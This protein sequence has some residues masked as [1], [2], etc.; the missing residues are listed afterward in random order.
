MNYTL[1]LLNG[2]LMI[3][4]FLIQIPFTG[5]M[6]NRIIKLIINHT[7]Q[8]MTPTCTGFIVKGQLKRQGLVAG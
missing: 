6:T 5:V 4:H 8:N 2:K 1:I 3:R 7:L